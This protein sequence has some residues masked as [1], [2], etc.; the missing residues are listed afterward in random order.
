MGKDKDQPEGKELEGPLQEIVSLEIELAYQRG[1][2][3]LVEFI[4]KTFPMQSDG[5][6]KVPAKTLKSF[7]DGTFKDRA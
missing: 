5:F 1:K 6:V 2:L 4:V 3:E 7:I